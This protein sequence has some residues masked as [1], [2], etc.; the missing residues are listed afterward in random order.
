MPQ[1]NVGNPPPCPLC[2]RPGELFLTAPDRFLGLRPQD[3]HQLFAC[4][5]CNHYYQA[6]VQDEY[7]AEFYPTVYYSHLRPS[8]VRSFIANVRVRN[9]ARA[10]EWRSTK[11][12]AIDVGCGVGLLLKELKRRG[13]NVVGTDWNA[14]NAKRVSAELGIPVIGGADGLSSVETSS[15]H[16]V[17]LFHVLEHT[18]NPHELLSELNR[19]LKPSGRI[20][21]V[22]PNA[23]S[24]AR[25]LFGTSWLGYD[26]PRHRHAFTPASLRQV[27]SA[28][29]FAIDRLT[30]RWSDE[31]LDIRGSATLYW[32]N[33][34]K[35]K[36]ILISA[37]AVAAA[38]LAVPG[39][40]VGGRSVICAYAHKV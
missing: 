28:N 23:A 17:S 19:I 32:R 12:N 6:P 25:A 36:G 27:L 20:V 7:L 39:R 11:G 3:H 15:Q 22:V 8:N 29:G 13:W 2:H 14:D 21:V 4:E 37:T 33:R 5:E 18:Q 40:L 9:R 1:Q 31:V 30:G 34:R 26:I 16:V 10:L 38:A 35:A 24:F